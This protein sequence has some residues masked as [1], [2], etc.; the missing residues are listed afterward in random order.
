MVE[1]E[2]ALDKVNWDIVGLSEIRKQ[3][4]GLFRRN[5]GYYFYYFGET[6]G[7]RGVGFIVKEKLWD[8]ILEIKGVNERICVLKL[9]IGLNVSMSVVQV[10]AP[11]LETEEVQLE[12]FYATLYDTVS[13][14]RGNF[15]IVMG[16][17]NAKVGAKI[18]NEFCVGQWGRRN[19]NNAGSKLVNLANQ[20]NLKI[21]NT[22]FKK[23]E[24]RRWTWVSPNQKTKNEIDHCLV[25][26]LSIV[27]DITVLN[28]FDFASDHRIG[29]CSLNIP[30]RARYRKPHRDGTKER[31]LKAII[32][33]WRVEEARKFL[34]DKINETKDQWQN[35]GMQES[36]DLLVGLIVKTIERYGKYKEKENTDDKISSKTKN[37]IRRREELRKIPNKSSQQMIEWTELQKLVRKEIKGDCRKF[38]EKMVEEIIEETWSSKKLKNK[39]SNG[40]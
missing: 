24:G 14:E 21:A 39:L 25:N 10:Y 22:F 23:K 15:T 20:L 18:S 29:R 4:E 38:E 16:D 28:Q 27:R 36:Y 33:Q 35:A 37:L 7:Y 32:P 2:A 40:S 17:F 13:K 12:E 31:L 8:K 11:T 3:G 19:R 30:A 26:E 1:F 6:K 9:E 34:R 5:K